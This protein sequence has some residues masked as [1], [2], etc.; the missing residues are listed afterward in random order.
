MQ[1]ETND[2]SRFI[3]AAEPWYF[4]M[5]CHKCKTRSTSLKNSLHADDCKCNEGLYLNSVKLID[6][7]EPGCA[8]QK[9]WKYA[10][11]GVEATYNGW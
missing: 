10:I 2:K 3:S 1:M 5:Q 4:T 7:S 6:Q 8:C 11:G 9:S